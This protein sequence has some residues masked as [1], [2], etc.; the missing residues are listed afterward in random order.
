M[1]V[2]G[3]MVTMA[4]L[5]QNSLLEALGMRV[6]PLRGLKLGR[7]QPCLEVLAPGWWGDSTLKGAPGLGPVAEA[8]SKDAPVATPLAKR[9]SI[10]VSGLFIL[11]RLGR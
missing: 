9:S 4:T 8:L 5:A 3:T 1:A 7:G 2:A 6:E 11:L 10:H